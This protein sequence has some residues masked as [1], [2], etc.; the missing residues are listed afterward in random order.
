MTDSAKLLNDA[1]DG[2]TLG[3]L[4]SRFG[5]GIYFPKGIVAQSAE[6]A[7]RA[8]RLNATAGMAYERGTAMIL[9]TVA[10]ALAGFEPGET[11]AYAPTAGVR[12]LRERWRRLIAAKNEGLSEEQIALPVVVP[13]LTHGIYQS[14][15]MLVDPGDGIVVP[16]LFWGNYRLMI[17]EQLN[18]GLAQWRFFDGGGLDLRSYREVLE[19]T[20]NAGKAIVLLNFPH[21]PTGYSP[22]AEE[23]RRLVAET[24][25]VAD[26]GADIAVICDDAYF[27]LVYEAQGISNRS[28]FAELAGAHPKIVA[29]KV[30]GTTK[31]DFAWGFR[32]G[33][34]TVAK[35]TLTDEQAA[36]WTEKLTGAV[37]SVVSSSSNLSQHVLLRALRSDSYDREKEAKLALLRERYRN[38]RAATTRHASDPVLT[39]LPY[40]S[41]Y[42]LTLS[43][44]GIDAEQLRN[45][46]LDEGIGVISI[47]GRYIRV[48]YA[49]VD[50]ERIDELFDAIF[51]AAHGLADAG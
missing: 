42:F 3:R 5:R 44:N 15:R 10:D 46:L 23:A 32:V 36:A 12:E 2:S 48:A 4:L 30:D 20:A 43:T 49:A 38:A 21:N 8:H 39:A 17:E 16:D 35:A 29:I 41:G 27:G 31:E 37:R 22:T 33:F 28:V 1:L 11:V 14:L 51:A 25:A 26:R 40:N 45:R 19:R 9:P 6:A 47:A 7:T 34:V 24:V 13:G 18:A 50:A